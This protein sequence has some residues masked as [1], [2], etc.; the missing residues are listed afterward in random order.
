MIT[1][2]GCDYCNILSLKERDCVIKAL[3]DTVI[4]T[5]GLLIKSKIFKWRWF[6]FSCRLAA[7]AARPS[8]RVSTGSSKRRRDGVNRPCSAGFT[9]LA[10]L[11][12]GSTKDS[13]NPE[14]TFADFSIQNCAFSDMYFHFLKY[15]IKKFFD[16][17]VLY[18]I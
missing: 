17:T 16:N 9:S 6:L 14:S 15:I 13:S 10:E 8:R 7:S 5:G 2:F 18:W 4:H 3:K 11:L 12:V 1:I